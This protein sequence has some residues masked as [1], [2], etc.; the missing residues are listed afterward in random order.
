M[1]IGLNEWERCGNDSRRELCCLGMGALGGNS[2]ENITDRRLSFREQVGYVMGK[3]FSS[4]VNLPRWWQRCFGLCSL[5]M[6]SW[7]L[8]YRWRDLWAGAMMVDTFYG[9]LRTQV[10]SQ[11]GQ[12]PSRYPE[13]ILIVTFFRW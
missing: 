12:Q 4:R 10:A 3:M 7:S 9:L 8:R 5:D 6:Q 11:V 13:V 2:G 1:V